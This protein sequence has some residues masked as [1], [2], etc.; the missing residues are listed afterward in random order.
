MPQ[1][2]FVEPSG[3]PITV[4]VPAGESLMR[5]AVNNDIDGVLGECG[6]ACCCATCHVYVD[7]ASTPDVPAIRDMEAQMLEHVAAPRNS[8]SRLACQIILQ[9]SMEGL[10]VR[11]PPTQL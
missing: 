4:D 8:N 10:I 7:E 5:A 11:L 9:P 2:T 6:G 3:T 1:V